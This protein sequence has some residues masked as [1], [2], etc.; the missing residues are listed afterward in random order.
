MGGS[1]GYCSVDEVK[2][3]ARGRWCEVLAAFGFNGDVLDGRHHPCPRC[4]GTDR[5]RLIDEDAGAVLCN[6]CF[7]EGNGDGLAAIQWRNGW[8]FSETIKAVANYLGIT[9]ANG[10]AKRRSTSSNL[11]DQMWII[12]ESESEYCSEF[13]A[14]FCKSK[15]PIT[16]D[17]IHAAG[18]IAVGWPKHKEH[19]HCCIA[20]PA[21]ER[22]G[23]IT[24]YILRRTDGED[25][26]A[27]RTLKERKTH[28]LNGSHDGWII[29]GGF[30]RVKQADVLWRVEGVP[31]AL[32]LFPTLPPNHVVVTNICGAKSSLKNLGILAGKIVFVVG[33]ADVPGQEGAIKFA[34][35]TVTVGD[36]VKIVPLPYDISDD[37]GKDLR[38]Y[39]N[40]GHTFAE[41]R[42]AAEGAEHFT[43]ATGKELLKRIRERKT[44]TAE[45]DNNQ[46]KVKPITLRV[47]NFEE[48]EVETDEGKEIEEVPLSI[49]A[50][51]SHIGEL[52]NNWPR[53]V[54]NSLFIPNPG[55]DGIAW[56]PDADSV[57]GFFGEA[58]GS[59]AEFKGKQGFHS[60]G[61]IF[62]YLIRTVQ[63]YAAVENLPHEPPTPNHFYAC[64]I[65]SSGTGDALRT[66][67]DR[68]SPETDIDRD[69]ILAAVVTPFWGGR[70]GARPAFC[71]TSDAG[72][73]VGK[74]TVVACISRLAGG[75]IEV[76]QNDDIGMVKTRLLSTDGLTKRIIWLDNVKSHKLSW[77]ELESLITMPTISG[78]KNYCGEG[79][80]PNNLTTY[81]T[82]NGVS[83]S[84]DLAQR[85]VLVKLVRPQYSATWAED[86]FQFIESH[87]RQLV[88]D[89]LGFLRSPAAT[90]AKFSRWGD[91]ERDILARLPEP[92]ETQAVIRE[93]QVGVDVD[94]EESALIEEYFAKQL[95]TLGYDIKTD[96]VFIPS[97]VAARWFGWATNERLTVAKA[98]RTL[99]QR[100]TEGQLHRLLECGRRDVGRG[101]EFW[102]DDATGE[103]H[104][105]RDIED[106]IRIRGDNQ[107][108]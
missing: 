82:M 23:E 31:D 99:K 57:F 12:K 45:Q 56:L 46:E 53:R 51:A 14:E 3:A 66:L 79:Q 27:F 33:D 96:R 71:F 30:G 63:E 95:T 74:S 15:P 94:G 38:D 84:T 85:C 48:I 97:R 75:M 67:I 7:T 10:H 101:F 21:F 103:T 107:V 36:Q 39:L 89:V 42:A 64:E 91:W 59:P 4:N 9:P 106:Q 5:F 78:K 34:S 55:R 72:K 90:L 108:A 44:K 52:T 69:L 37:H 22:P 2:L 100:I 58:T 8:T 50:I 76:S 60:K 40:E 62:S 81:L 28:V 32:A 70:C 54:G 61:E 102:G 98:S 104:L 26:P 18:G 77:G 17:A 29:P 20:F 92:A 86:I 88:A 24:G 83:L 73:G 11:L 47:S 43:P 16:P 68:F 25:F 49:V 80:R 6:Q 13:F 35:K 93:R 41:L 105:L 1:N 65:P 87:R 19:G